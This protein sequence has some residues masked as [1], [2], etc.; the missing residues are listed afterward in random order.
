M[1]DD[2]DDDDDDDYGYKAGKR[3]ALTPVSVS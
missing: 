3:K 1:D 2:D